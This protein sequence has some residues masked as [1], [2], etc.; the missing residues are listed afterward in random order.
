MHLGHAGRSARPWL[1]MYATPVQGSLVVGGLAEGGPAQRAGMRLGDVLLEVGGEPVTDLAQLFRRV[2]SA[3]PA[4]AQI[5]ITV[6]RGD[7]TSEVS[8]TSADRN[9]FLLKP[10]HH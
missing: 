1:G 8:I 2:W 7:N 5:A 3:G 4:G 10:L 9:D 6:G